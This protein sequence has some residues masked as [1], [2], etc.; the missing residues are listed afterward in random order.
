MIVCL[1]LGQSCEWEEI[2]RSFESYDAY[3]LPG[4]VRPF[5]VHG[6][7]EPLLIYYEGD[8]ARAV[9]VVMKRDIANDARFAGK[10]H[11]GSLFDLV[12]PYGYG[13]WLF[14]GDRDSHFFNE[15]EKWCQANNIVSEFIRFHPVLQNQNGLEGFYEVLPLGE[16]I[17][18]DLASEDDIWANLTSKNRNMIRKAQKNGLVVE[19]GWNRELL[20][21]F[22]LIYN[23]TMDA[24]HAD[25]YYYFDSEFYDALCL[26]MKDGAELFYCK[27]G[28]KVITASVMLSVNGFMSYHLSGSI[29]EYRNLAPT[30]L[31]LYEAAVWGARNGCQGLHLGGGVGSSEDSLF[32]FKKSFMRHERGRCR[33][34]IGR[35]IHMEDIYCDLVS[36]REELPEN[37]FFPRYRA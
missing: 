5:Q 1:I 21:Q 18:M 17:L 35:K 11:R 13:G 12:T 33:F 2:V 7:G 8:S 27:F 23:Q 26:G 10:I 19:H 36:M 20:E 16:T 31:L 6:D 15:Y 22:R 30:N 14:E 4:Y 34:H 32:S 3:Y 24:D 9:N 37:D 29:R 25:A 28:D